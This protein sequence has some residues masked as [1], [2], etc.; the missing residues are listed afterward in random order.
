MLYFEKK[1]KEILNVLD[2][3]Q[4]NMVTLDELKA[5]QKE[6]QREIL[7]SGLEVDPDDNYNFLRYEKY[8][9]LLDSIVR[10]KVAKEKIKA[11][12]YA[13]KAN[14]FMERVAFSNEDTTGPLG[15]IDKPLL[16]FDNNTYIYLKKY[17]PLERI[18]KKYQFVYSPAHL[19]EMANSIRRED[20]KYNESIER[21]L[22]YL[23]N[24][25]NNVEFLPN[26]QKGI[27]V[28]SESPYNP[29][30]RVI[31]NFD[32]TVLS[33]EMEQDFMENRSRIKAE[34]SL[35]VKGSTIEGVL[36]ST[37]AKKAL[38]SFDW[39]PE[40]EQEAEKR[41]FWEKHKNSYSFLFTDLACIDRIVDTL[42]NNPEPARKYRSHMHDTTHLIY[43]T[44][45]DIFVT[46]D[47]RL[48]DKATEIFRF[49]GIP[50]KV[51]D[52][53]EFLPEMTNA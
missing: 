44:Q 17:V 50:G 52:Y 46:N 48:Y 14:D 19:E 30:R 16:Y 29:L 27:V 33:E 3:Y 9:I 22:R 40:Y 38:S 4:R 10:E 25:T 1:E 21:D 13:I 23:G 26:L 34:L 49:L 2:K 32:G 5:F 18:T 37:A 7:A 35:K 20:F 31:E 39:Y 12:V 45:S 11:H 28:K 47:G 43:A 8:W 24:L 15:K 53:K 42:D 6:V 51:V 36:S 41:L